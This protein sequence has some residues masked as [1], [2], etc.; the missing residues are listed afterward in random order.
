MGS[1]VDM[2]IAKCK[3]WNK[4]SIILN[5]LVEYSSAATFT[6]GLLQLNARS[7]H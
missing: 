6:K 7:V 2:N 1:F 5:F 3:A 4:F